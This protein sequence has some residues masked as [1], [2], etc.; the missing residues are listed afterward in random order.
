MESSRSILDEEDELMY[1][2]QRV[3]QTNQSNHFNL[4]TLD[5]Q[6]IDKILEPMDGIEDFLKDTA[7]Q[8]E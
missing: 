8:K 1:D 5:N 7:E 6:I 4:P 2:Q 3:P